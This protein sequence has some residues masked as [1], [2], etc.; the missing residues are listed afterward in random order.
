MDFWSTVQSVRVVSITPRDATSVLARLT[1]DWREGHSTTEDRWLSVAIV[2]GRLLISDSAVAN[3]N[4][5]V[6]V[7]AQPDSS[8]AQAPK[9]SAY[10]KEFLSLMSQ[11]GWGC[12]DNSDA[13]QCQRKMVS[14]AHQVCS[15]S[16]V[17]I[18][19]I[20]QNFPVPDYFGPREERRAIANAQQAY[21]NCTFTGS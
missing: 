8:A 19:V 9:M 3:S 12:T 18:D 11:E 14:F 4:S 7:T 17:S 21:P 2:N 16:G 5:T 1:Y 20:Y 15:Y 6:T 13:E 10:D